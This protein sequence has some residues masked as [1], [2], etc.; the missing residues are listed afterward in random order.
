LLD[1]VR[2]AHLVPVVDFKGRRGSASGLQDGSDDSAALE[3]QNVDG[4]QD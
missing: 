3:A 1:E 2:D 4:G